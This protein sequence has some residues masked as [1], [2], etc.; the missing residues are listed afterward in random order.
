MGIGGTSYPMLR[1]CRQRLVTR[2]ARFMRNAGGQATIELAAAIPVFII[3]LT[4]ATNALAFFADC[5]VFDRVAHDAVRVY[6]SS[7]AY[8]QTAGQSCALVE[9][10]LRSVLD[11]DNV[12]VRVSYAPAGIDLDQ[13]TATIEYS[14]TLFGLGLR[15]EVF[16]VQLPVLTHVTTYVVDGY[17]PGLVV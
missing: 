14:P 4:I 12:R 5:A 7:P 1:L 13:Y 6:A 9:S 16:G 17:K 3:V 10:E 2:S 11:A 8:G 15:S